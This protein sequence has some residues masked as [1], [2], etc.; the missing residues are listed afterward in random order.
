ML[1]FAAEL[2]PSVQNNSIGILIGSLIP[3]NNVLMSE[4]FM[5]TLVQLPDNDIYY[6]L[7]TI[8]N[9]ALNRKEQ[10]SLFIQSVTLELFKV[11][12][13]DSVPILELL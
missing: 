13:R 3:E 7:T 9:M 8:T 12:I 6:F 2:I 4:E 11:S 10:D 1:Y 5:E